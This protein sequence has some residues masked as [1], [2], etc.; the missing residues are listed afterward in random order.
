LS[1]WVDAFGK[2]L[3]DSGLKLGDVANQPLTKPQ[4]QIADVLRSGWRALLPILTQLMNRVQTEALLQTTLNC[5][6]AF[7]NISGSLNLSAPKE[8]FL[9]TLAQFCTVTDDNLNSR[10]ILACKTLFNAAHCLGAVLDA[11]DWH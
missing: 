1:H 4:S 5:F 9:S 2:L 10:Q 3:E 8:S 11:K 7:F 6:Q